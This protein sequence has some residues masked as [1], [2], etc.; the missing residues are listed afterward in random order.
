MLPRTVVAFVDVSLD[1][2]DDDDEVS[3]RHF[4]VELTVRKSFGIFAI[5][6]QTT[7]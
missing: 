1:E 5:G 2:D 6:L 7:S 3:E 4:Q